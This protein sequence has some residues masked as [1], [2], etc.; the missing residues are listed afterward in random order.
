MNLLPLHGFTLADIDA[1]LF[2]ATVGGRRHGALGAPVRGHAAA[3]GRAAPPGA[4]VLVP[5][6][7]GP[8]ARISR[9]IWASRIS[10]AWTSRL[11]LGG[12]ALL[13]VLPYSFTVDEVRHKGLS[14]LSLML[15]GD[16]ARVLLRPAT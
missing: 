1:A 12:P 14:E 7:R 16:Q 4:G 6:A 5:L 8:C 3:A 2:A 15:Y 11:S 13:R 10:A 9:S